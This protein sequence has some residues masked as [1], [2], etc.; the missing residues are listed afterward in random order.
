MATRPEETPERTAFYNKIDTQNLTPLWSV[1]ADLVTP[2]PKSKCRPH[3]WRFADIKAALTEAGGLITAKE[4]ER[5]VLILEKSRPT[6]RI[7]NHH[8]A[9]RRCANGAARRSRPGSPP[10]PI[11]ATL[12]ARRIRCAYSSQR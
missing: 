7:Q 5:R 11:G 9:L 3:L 10:Y 2:E 6:R 12:C 1:L 4:A 8:V